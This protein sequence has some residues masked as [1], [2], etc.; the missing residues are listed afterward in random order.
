MKKVSKLRYCIVLV[1]FVNQFCLYSMDKQSR[2]S[3]DPPIN[4]ASK[5]KKHDT[6][7][8]FERVQK[9]GLRQSRLFIAC[10][11]ARQSNENPAND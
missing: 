2:K 7:T 1:C 6:R 11:K 3:A 8:P 10:K 5:S 9:E 4:S